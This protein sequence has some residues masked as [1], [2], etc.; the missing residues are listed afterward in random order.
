M[1]P[2]AANLRVLGRRL[3]IAAVPLVAAAAVVGPATGT[4]HAMEPGPANCPSLLT[5]A[6]DNW[7]ESDIWTFEAEQA[8]QQDDILTWA[9]DNALSS[10]YMETGDHYYDLY[11][12]A[13]C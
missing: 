5:T 12:A 9:E 4:A 2:H 3:V 1:K 13:R 7:D 8:W 6:Y 11:T 10:S